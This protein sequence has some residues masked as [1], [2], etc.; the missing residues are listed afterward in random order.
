MLNELLNILQRFCNSLNAIFLY[1]NLLNFAECVIC[2]NF[3]DIGL[4]LVLRITLY[5]FT[6]GISNGVC[7]ICN[8]GKC[9]YFYS[10]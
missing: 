10:Y 3:D 9:T 5:C 4:S 7:D 2:N 1:V 6:T 8:K